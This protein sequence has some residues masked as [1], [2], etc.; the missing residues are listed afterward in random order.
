MIKQI[1]AHLNKSIQSIIGQKVE[2]VKQDEQAFTRKR[3]LSLE[4]MIRTILG[5][6]GK[7][8]SKEFTAPIPLN[9]DFPIF[10]ADGS[11]ICIPRNP[12]DTETSIQTQ[13]D[14]KSYNLIHINALYDLTTGVYRDVSIQDKHAQH[15]RL[16]LIQMME[17]SPF[18]E[19]SCYHG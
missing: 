7:S 16:A 6:G 3:R 13:T 2:F 11:D 8:L 1:K 5:M 14:V 15:E 19:S 9:T 17:A 10:A 12:M 18:R 4:T